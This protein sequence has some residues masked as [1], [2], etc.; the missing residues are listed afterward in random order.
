MDQLGM[1][2]RRGCCLLY[3]AKPHGARYVNLPLVR[4]L[5]CPWLLVADT[6]KDGVFA[7]IAGTKACVTEGDWELC[8]GVIVNRLRGEVQ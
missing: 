5:E 2:C 1:G 7:E 6:D 3:R 4:K 8:C